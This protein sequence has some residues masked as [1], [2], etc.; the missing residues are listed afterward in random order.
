M[1]IKVSIIIPCKNEEKYIETLLL[2]LV[3]QRLPQ[4]F[5]V[6]VADAKSTDKTLDIIQSYQ[7]KLPNLRVVD[8]GLPSVG[9]NLGA[10]AAKGDIFLFIDA[11]CY[12]KKPNHI[13]DSVAHLEKKNADL[14]GCFLNAEN[15][16][17]LKMIYFMCNIVFLLSKLDDPFVVGGYFMIRK[18]TFFSCGGFDEELMHCEDYFLSKKIHKDR[19]Q[20]FNGFIYSDDRRFRK[21]G[22]WNT[23]KYFTK[24]TIKR[25]DEDYF[26]KDIGYW[27]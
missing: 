9:R 27:S 17:L 19:F 4:S 24:N 10:K 21:L 3:K 18:E 13:I 2:S 23:V 1:E 26:K 11:D 15:N 22:Y 25:N 5:E 6:I 8:G 20:L 7:N 12:V 16:L 14:L